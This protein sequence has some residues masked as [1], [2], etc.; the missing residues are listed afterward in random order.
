MSM[1]WKEPAMQVRMDSEA[2]MGSAKGKGS[3]KRR[4]PDGRKAPTA[5]QAARGAKEE[6]YRREE[7]WL[8]QLALDPASFAEV[9]REVHAKMRQ[10]A[11]LFVAGLLARA[12]ERSEMAGA[13][14]QVLENAETPLR[15]VEKKDGR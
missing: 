2:Q 1:E 13:V 11:D 10:H 6:L 15:A 8:E 12:S 5:R 14:E 9:E 4:R 3:G 7:G